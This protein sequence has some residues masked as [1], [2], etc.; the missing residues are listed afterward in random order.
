M[1]KKLDRTFILR[2]GAAAAFVAVLAAPQIASAG[3]TGTSLGVS[4]TVAPNCTVAANPTLAFGNYIGQQ[5]DAQQDIV[6]T[7]TSGTTF[8]VL[9]D[10]G[11]NGATTSARQMSDG[12]GHTLNYALYSD[13]SRGSN[14]GN[15]DPTDTTG[16][17]GTGASQNVTVYGR[18]PASQTSPLAV[19]GDTVGVTITF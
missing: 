6:V 7:C 11:L 5:L 15:N 2:V 16:G 1:S 17:T 14:W 19:Y 13:S 9:L 18:I 10:K 8:R 12:S 4:A 3:S